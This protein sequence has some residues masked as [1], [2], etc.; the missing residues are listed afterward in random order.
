MR[1]GNPV[2]EL[3]N[4][5][6]T[7]EV[8]FLSRLPTT[9]FCKVWQ[10][11]TLPLQPLQPTLF[12]LESVKNVFG[13]WTCNSETRKGTKGHTLTKNNNNNA[14][15]K[16][17]SSKSLKLQRIPQA[18]QAGTPRTNALG[19]FIWTVHH[20]TLRFGWFNCERAPEEL[21][22]STQRGNTSTYVKGKPGTSLP[23]PTTR[24]MSAK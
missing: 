5:F 12:K 2:N 8:S 13:R 1:H 15:A 24:C 16:I 6:T 23:D 9:P 3:K 10:Q 19:H 7:M 18:V 11:F 21:S 4:N 14:T 17:L 20:A 22:G